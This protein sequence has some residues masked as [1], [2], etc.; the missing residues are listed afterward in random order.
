MKYL[1]VEINDI[2]NIEHKRDMRFHKWN[3]SF[4]GIQ[5]L[6]MKA[7]PRLIYRITSNQY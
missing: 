4:N 7:Y 5:I 1:A 2:T 3:K 6:T